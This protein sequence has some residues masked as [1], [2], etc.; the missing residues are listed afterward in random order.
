MIIS[1]TELKKWRSSDDSKMCFGDTVLES[2]ALLA[3]PTDSFYAAMR[4][5]SHASE[6]FSDLRESMNEFDG[7]G[8]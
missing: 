3:L 1:H 6:L 4:L 2:G 8:T 7:I 5:T